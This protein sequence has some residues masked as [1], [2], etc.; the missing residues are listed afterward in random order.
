MLSILQT[1]VVS[2]INFVTLKC[3]QLLEHLV[4]I[5]DVYLSVISGR[6][7]KNVKAM[8]GMDDIT[9]AGVLTNWIKFEPTL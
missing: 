5:P 9:Y 4:S 7:V 8:V 1:V 6:S 3:F 2:S